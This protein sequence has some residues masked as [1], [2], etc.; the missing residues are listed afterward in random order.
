[1]TYS[2][3]ALSKPLSGPVTAAAGRRAFRAA[4][5]TPLFIANWQPATLIC[6]HSARD[7]R[8]PRAAAL[9]TSQLPVQ[10]RLV[11]GLRQPTPAT[12][13]YSRGIPTSNTGQRSFFP[14]KYYPYVQQTAQDLGYL[15][16]LDVKGW[17]LCITIYIRQLSLQL[18]SSV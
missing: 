6:L 5:W 8:T 16:G 15:S 1:M 9:L 4:R 14:A 10:C 2:P 11:P 17:M 7:G 18:Y 13:M 12:R 3:T